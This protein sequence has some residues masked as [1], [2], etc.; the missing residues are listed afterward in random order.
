MPLKDLKTQ[1][2]LID[3]ILTQQD[4]AVRP[5]A[6]LLDRLIKTGQRIKS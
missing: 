2:Q 4:L 6:G 1:I 3:L 5:P